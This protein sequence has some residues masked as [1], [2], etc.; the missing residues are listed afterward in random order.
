MCRPILGR[1]MSTV[2]IGRDGDRYHSIVEEIKEI[3]REEGYK[4][5]GVLGADGLKDN[6]M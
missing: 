6:V 5:S 3:G 4:Y 2:I 1:S